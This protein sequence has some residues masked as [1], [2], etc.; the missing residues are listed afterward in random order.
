M[1]WFEDGI[2]E[3]YRCSLCIGSFEPGSNR[4]WTTNF[5]RIADL[6]YY[7][8]KAILSRA[9]NTSPYS[10][11][12]A[13]ADNPPNLYHPNTVKAFKDRDCD[14][15]YL[16]WKPG[17]ERADRPNVLDP[18]TN[19]YPADLPG[20]FEVIVCKS[21]KDEADLREKLSSGIPFVGKTTRRF[22]L[23]YKQERSQMRA[24][25]CNRSDFNFSD[26]VMRLQV[27]LD[28]PRMTALSV[29]TCTISSTDIIELPPDET[30]A[31][32]KVYELL[33]LPKEDGRIAVR[34]LSYYAGDFV[35]WLINEEDIELS[36][37]QRKKLAASVNNCLQKSEIFSDYLGAEI[38]EEEERQLRE[39]IRS[40]IDY[41]DD[42][43]SL[44]VR[45][46]LEEDDQF[47]ERCCDYVFANSN[48]RLAEKNAELSAVQAEIEERAAA[49][50]ELQNEEFEVLARTEEAEKQLVA[51][52]SSIEELETQKE[53]VLDALQDNIA[54]RLGLRSVAGLGGGSSA[55]P[56]RVQQLLETEDLNVEEADISLEEAI[57]TNLKA[58]GIVGVG[59]SDKRRERLSANIASAMS[60][61]NFLAMGQEIAE[62]CAHAVSF[63]VGGCPACRVTVPTNCCDIDSLADAIASADGD[64]V[65]VENVIDTINESVLFALARRTIGKTVIFPIGAFSNLRLIAPEAW[66]RI[67][68]VNDGEVF[69]A[70]PC[71]KDLVRC[72]KPKRA[73]VSKDDLLDELSYLSGRLASLDIPLEL[74]K[75]PATALCILDSFENEESD[76][77]AIAQIAFI[78]NRLGKEE[79]VDAVSSE[80]GAEHAI[81]SLE[82][83]VR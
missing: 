33:D 1:R 83:R 37:A 46:A 11:E 43:V 57:E 24:L 49:I 44:L 56:F 12:F 53:E 2:F 6:E 45:T 40:S 16:L 5:P 72:S 71:W 42:K 76:L 77:W 62:A 55:T 66:S 64:A 63:A 9:D 48:E 39:A 50:E 69:R 80:L 78:G 3:G 51:L 31:F 25:I 36:K 26:G 58:S 19:D 7:G 32:R 73:K 28:N 29:P 38:S 81:E 13:D 8:G 75:L 34:P 20:C 22:L 79:S 52:S 65:L 27:K 18:Y 23:V 10:R 70:G 30:G 68:I 61:T 54:L 59:G 17:T 67:A 35:K 47:F 15:I 41:G 21:I 4:S 60:A 74:L 14:F 82:S